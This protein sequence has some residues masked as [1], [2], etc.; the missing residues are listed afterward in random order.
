MHKTVANIIAGVIPFR[1][2][3]RCVRR[4]LMGSREMPDIVDILTECR[5][6]VNYAQFAEDVV[7]YKYLH[8][9][10]N[11]FYVDVGA[12]DPVVF[13]VT[14]MFY[15]M[16]WSGINIEPRNDV[17]ELYSTER[18]RDV[19]LALAASDRTGS[20][21]MHLASMESS[22]NPDAGGGGGGETTMVQ[23]DTLHAIL[24][25]HPL[26][27][28]HFLKIDVEQHEKEVL[29]GMDFS[30]ARPWI[31]V[32]EAA[33]PGSGCVGNTATHRSWEHI[34]FDNGYSFLAQHAIN[35]YYAANEKRRELI[36]NALNMAKIR[37][38]RHEDLL[39]L[40]AAQGQ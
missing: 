33:I 34:L 24:A 5:L 13:S 25:R 9:V 6:L 1:A 23:L 22:L 15:D 30:S 26:P 39:A 12:A 38:L 14:K 2:T 29:Q 4:R 10:E 16:G 18:K 20:A 8:H 27:T 28:I 19:N 35:R 21:I 11:G 3:R 17:I 32:M 7:L 40:H 36:A 31:I 37:Y